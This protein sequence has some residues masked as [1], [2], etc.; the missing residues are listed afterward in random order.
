ML[1]ANAPMSNSTTIPNFV[2][3]TPPTPVPN[4][5]QR[6]SVNPPKPKRNVASIHGSVVFIPPS[7]CPQAV[8]N[9]CAAAQAPRLYQG[10]DTPGHPT[11]SVFTPIGQDPNWVIDNATSGQ[12]TTSPTDVAA[13]AAKLHATA[14]NIPS[15]DYA[16]G[17]E[18][19]INMVPVSSINDN[20]CKYQ[21][22]GGPYTGPYLLCQDTRGGLGN[23]TY[24][25]QRV[26]FTDCGAGHD[27][28]WTYTYLKLTEPGTFYTIII[29]DNWMDCDGGAALNPGCAD[30]GDT[31]VKSI[32]VTGG[33]LTGSTIYVSYN[34]I[35][36]EYFKWGPQLSPRPRGWEG[37]TDQRSAVQTVTTFDHNYVHNLGVDYAQSGSTNNGSDFVFTYNAFLG[38]A[39]DGVSHM[40]I[41]EE[42]GYTVYPGRN[43]SYIGNVCELQSVN[44]GIDI[45]ACQYV[46]A[47][48][49][50]GQSFQSLTDTN[51]IGIINISGSTCGTPPITAA[52]PCLTG[53]NGG[54]GG[55]FT[56]GSTATVLTA[57]FSQNILDA[58]GPGPAGIPCW[59]NNAGGFAFNSGTNVSI[60]GN[61]MTFDGINQGANPQFLTPPGM[62]FHDNVGGIG[63][64]DTPTIPNGAPGAGTW[65]PWQT[66]I[67]STSGT[68]LTTQDPNVN[69]IVG[70][71]VQHVD[72]PR[73]YLNGGSTGTIAS[74]I[75]STHWTLSGAGMGT[76]P[77]GTYF[78][79]DNLN[80]MTGGHPCQPAYFP[81]CGTV[82]T[83]IS[84]P[85]ASGLNGT[86][87]VGAAYW[88]SITDTGD[89]YV[90]QGTGGLNS[91]T[92]TQMNNRANAW[93]CS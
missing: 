80:P 60:S 13:Y 27:T 8:D 4:Y 33:A 29:N 83:T 51:N 87:F 49:S 70:R 6:P 89:N 22:S 18:N 61:I 40:E 7:G 71:S 39:N 20:F 37:F 59:R 43:V 57:L 12:T 44:Y 45:T 36:D 73:G 19:Y 68:T 2:T 81:N 28:C 55:L 21:A 17:S 1:G 91:M 54:D 23:I 53:P 66:F 69:L 56:A 11:G 86:R 48:A 82:V 3:I 35:S 52:T 62:T 92:F 14:L 24:I 76:Y 64:V 58:T 38:L 74:Q 50:N 25:L 5:I 10:S 26:D 77:P 42:G 32:I 9:G 85:T 79:S 34:N 65:N 31:G 78:R 41:M 16:V 88:P 93:G 46:S 72:N 90:F 15:F 84:E 67:G 30:P 63:F 47:G 75:D